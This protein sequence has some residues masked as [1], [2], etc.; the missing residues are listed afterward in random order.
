M[1]V[2]LSFES[3]VALRL[4]WAEIGIRHRAPLAVSR[5]Q[6]R[7]SARSR[8]YRVEQHIHEGGA[9]SE[10]GRELTTDPEQYCRN[11]DRTR[12]T[13]PGACSPLATRRHLE[14]KKRRL[15]QS[16]QQCGCRCSGRLQYTE[17]GR[18]IVYCRPPRRGVLFL[19]PG[20]RM[21]S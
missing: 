5:R 20:V 1:N 14:W 13:S 16:I 10:R 4:F 12:R 17:P 6:K 7:V 15:N 19:Q 3:V 18:D 21:D 8:P 9:S 2:V 11:P